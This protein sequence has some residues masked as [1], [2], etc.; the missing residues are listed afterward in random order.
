[1]LSTQEWNDLE[2]EVQSL[3]K[4]RLY[5]YRKIEDLVKEQWYQICDAYAERVEDIPGVDLI[6]HDSRLNHLFKVRV[7]PYYNRVF[8]EKVTELLRKSKLVMYFKFK[9][10]YPTNWAVYSLGINPTV[11]NPN[12]DP[13][14]FNP[15]TSNK[16]RKTLRK[17]PL[18]NGE[19][20]IQD[21]GVETE[22]ELPEV[23]EEE[24]FLDVVNMWGDSSTS[25][26][27]NIPE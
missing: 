21:A 20:F 14:T 24:Y 22:A 25:I 18:E 15:H 2:N 16:R 26:F 13:Q 3:N 6:L 23:P 9:K 4:T 19:N 11:G 17:T 8:T 5:K 27:P 12:P 7:G 10:E 1:M